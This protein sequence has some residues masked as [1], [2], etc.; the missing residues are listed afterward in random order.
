[1]GQKANVFV[2][3][4]TGLVRE[5]SW[6]DA[7]AITWNATIIFSLIIIVPAVG[8]FPQTNVFIALI[9]LF[10]LAIFYS[11]NFGWLAIAMPRSGGPYVYNTRILHPAIGFA[12]ELVLDVNYLLSAASIFYLLN[13]WTLS[14]VLSS[15]G[16]TDLATTVTTPVPL[17]ALGCVDIIIAALLN[18]FPSRV[19]DWW[20]K[21][22]IV[23]SLIGGAIILPILLSAVGR[24]PQIFTQATGVDY[25][26]IIPL[27]MAH[28]F[29]TGHNWNST[30]LTL[31]WLGPFWL[32]F[33]GIYLAG[34]VRNV[35]KSML[36]A[37]LG[38]QVTLMISYVVF[39][40]GTYLVAGYDWYN[41][42]SWLYDNASSV[43]PLKTD[44]NI[45]NIVGLIAPYPWVKPVVAITM[46]LSMLAL[47]PVFHIWIS[48]GTFMWAFDR[49]LPEKYTEVSERFHTP[50]LS[51]VVT[52]ILIII[53]FALSV[54]TGLFTVWLNASWL[55]ALGILVTSVS[56][57][58]L[59]YR[60]KK[61]YDAAPSIVR[62][63]VAGI[64]LV[65]IGGAGTLIFMLFFFITAAVNPS[66][67]P[68]SV[69]QMLSIGVW[70]IGG[71]IYFYIAKYYR[72]KQGV[73]ISIAY[74][75]LPPL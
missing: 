60:G 34:E 39:V 64:P 73:D 41:A 62:A 49:L 23:V 65:S 6:F 16:F 67:N 24:F 48:R 36:W 11:I 3:D 69:P 5:F 10:V 31:A 15:L 32:G 1:L 19:L 38:A 26:S 37:T 47:L 61:I 2:R 56:G 44:P 75:E 43:Y 51:L 66:I 7:F 70:F 53:A 42:L 52:T 17:F 20:F 30:I 27:A 57:I 25:N 58:L 35:K 68:V 55:G 59:P 13:S 29:Q 50:V 74:K 40:A 9:L 28:G 63:K 22:T 8:L 54:F 14:W 12:T 45:Q 46:F 21:I 72:L 71:I 33:G 18:I 4:A